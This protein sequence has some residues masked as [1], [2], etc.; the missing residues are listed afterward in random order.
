MVFQNTEFGPCCIEHLR[1]PGS[2]LIRK[3]QGRWNKSASSGFSKW[4]EADFTIPNTPAS[5]GKGRG[6]CYKSGDDKSLLHH[7][8]CCDNRGLT[9]DAQR[10]G[11]RDI[12]NRNVVVSNVPVRLG[13]RTS[14][15]LWSNQSDE[16]GLV[17]HA[18]PSRT[19]LRYPTDAHRSH[20][21][22]IDSLDSFLARFRFD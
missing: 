1:L 12:S 20:S 5:G 7:G 10:H 14:S 6:G 2:F 17:E 13:A 15:M 18:R 4:K 22:V 21:A 8:C 11:S 3:R 16:K 19:R 9:C